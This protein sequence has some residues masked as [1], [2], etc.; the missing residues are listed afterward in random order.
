MFTP[1]RQVRLVVNVLNQVDRSAMDSHTQRQIV[2]A[3]QRAADCYRATHRR[4]RAG[5]KRQHHPVTG[6]YPDQLAGCFRCSELLGSADDPIELPLALALFVSQELGIADDIEK[7][8]M[9]NLELRVA[10]AICGHKLF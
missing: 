5:E 3:A 2:P 8:N 10:L 6:G 4:I 1:A 9:A 7:Q